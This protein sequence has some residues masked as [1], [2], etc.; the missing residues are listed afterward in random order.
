MLSKIKDLSFLKEAL[1][2]ST[3]LAFLT[4]YSCTLVELNCSVT[5]CDVVLTPHCFAKSNMPFNFNNL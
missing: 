3:I 4:M 2:T 5:R 1:E